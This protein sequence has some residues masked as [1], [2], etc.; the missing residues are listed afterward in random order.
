MGAITTTTNTVSDWL[1]RIDASRNELIDAAKNGSR[2]SAAFAMAEARVQLIE[3]LTDE[4]IKARLLRMTDPRINMVELAN[5]PTD[6]DRI[7]V[8]AIAILSGFCPGDDQ[9]AV[10]GGKGGGKLYTKEAGFRTLFAHLGIVPE[11]SVG[12]PEFVPLGK[13]G[14]KI[15]RVEGKASCSYGG[16]EY[17]VEFAGAMALGLPGYESDNV[18]GITAKGRRQLLKALWTKVSPILNDDHADDVE[19]IPQTLLIEDPQHVVE[20][21]VLVAPEP[22]ETEK[23]EP[24]LARIRKILADNPDQ[25]TFVESVWNEIAAA[26][27]QEKLEEAGKELAAMK[28]SVSSQVLSLVRPFYQ[29]RQAELKGG[30]A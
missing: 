12:H 8:C 18:A 17:A 11:V 23:H 30:A 15:W 16:K 13:S 20:D 19:I 28:A 2:I 5:N 25:L 10:F 27:T 26:R 21:S 24:S 3:S 22:S 29:S 1:T 9:F 6:E 7:R 4:N 14:K